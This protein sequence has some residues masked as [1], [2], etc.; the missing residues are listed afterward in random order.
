MPRFYDLP[1]ELLLMI[2]REMI[3]FD[4]ALNPSRTRPIMLHGATM[5]RT[6]SRLVAPMAWN[7]HF[8]SMSY[9][10]I[11]AESSFRLRQNRQEPLLQRYQAPAAFPAVFRHI[12]HLVLDVD[13]QL[14]QSQFDQGRFAEGVAL[15]ETHAAHLR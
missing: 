13:W 1:D 6:I 4:C 5:A 8:L 7:D 14:Q 9:Q 2:I 10:A 15:G 12:R 11:L 3:V